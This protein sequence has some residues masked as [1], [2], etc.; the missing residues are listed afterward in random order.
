M[1]ESPYCDICEGCGEVGCDGIGAFLE[2]HVRGNT[3]CRYEEA[4]IADIIWAYKFLK[5][6]KLVELEWVIE[7]IKKSRTTE[8]GFVEGKR[9]ADA[10][11]RAVADILISLETH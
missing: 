7:L 1:E 5:D 6:D 3:Q 10:R 4:F 9:E 2:K 8:E 11:V